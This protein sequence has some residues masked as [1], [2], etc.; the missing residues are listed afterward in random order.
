MHVQW[1]E[2]E[3]DW[4]DPIWNKSTRLYWINSV[5]GIDKY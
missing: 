3:K 5:S 2:K 4:L 1:K